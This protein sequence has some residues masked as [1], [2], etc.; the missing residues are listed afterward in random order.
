MKDIV[1]GA[2]YSMYVDRIN[3]KL[4]A[5]GTRTNVIDLNTLTICKRYGVQIYYK[6]FV[7]P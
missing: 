1:A 3:Q 2:P 6:N 7:Y 4:Y 5:V